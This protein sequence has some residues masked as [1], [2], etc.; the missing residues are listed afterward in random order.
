MPLNN[1]GNASITGSLTIG[2][3]TSATQ[4]NIFT[5]SVST[6]NVM[7]EF[8]N[9]DYTSG[10]RNFIR[11][12]NQ[13]STGSTMSSYFGQGQD[14]KT[15]IVS[16]DFTKNH[17]V[18]DGNSANVGI[19]TNTPG[20][21][22][23]VKHPSSH[24][25]LSLDNTASTL[26]SWMLLAAGGTSKWLMGLEGSSD[27][28]YLYNTVGTAGYRFTLTQAGNL[29][30]GG[31]FTETSSH[32]YKD[33]IETVENGLDKVL[34]MRGVT[35]IKKDTGIKELGLIAEEINEILPEAVLK[36]KEGEPD[37][38]SYGRITAVLIEAIKEQQ[39]QIEEL[40]ALIK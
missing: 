38:V 29:T 14:G 30:I 26:A 32:R 11:V 18:I 36:N 19:G 13:I 4:L 28:F 6:Q 24:T 17:I 12:R 25:Y 3:S 20:Y 15:Y 34:Q 9:S 39:K 35:Y 27:N 16:N 37:S 33:N 2:A 7:T 8:Y 5:S 31:T 22:L 23:T 21:L 1:A 10:T 40:K